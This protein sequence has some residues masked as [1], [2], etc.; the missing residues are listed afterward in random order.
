MPAPARV[1]PGTHLVNSALRPEGDHRPA[2]RRAVQPRGAACPTASRA[3]PVARPPRGFPP[4]PALPIPPTVPRSRNS[5]RHQLSTT[6]A[7]FSSRLA[8]AS[9]AVRI[10]RAGTPSEQ[11]PHA[12]LDLFGAAGLSGAASGSRLSKSKLATCR[13]ELIPSNRATPF[14]PGLPVEP[15]RPDWRGRAD[16]TDRPDQRSVQTRPTPSRRM[17][18]HPERT[19]RPKPV[20]RASPRDVAEGP[21]GCPRCRRPRRLGWPALGGGQRP[22]AGDTARVASRPERWPRRMASRP[23]GR[24]REPA[25]HPTRTWPSRSNGQLAGSHLTGGH[26]TSGHGPTA[27][28]RT[29]AAHS[30]GRTRHPGRSTPDDAQPAGEARPTNHHTRIP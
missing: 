24:P 1:V 22:A 6:T 3:Q 4:T 28:A 2:K 18:T 25:S 19:R 10:S 16:T 8:P 26:R 17:A 27:T 23:D 29:A 9:V 30:A 13:T 7:S 20:D 21:T 12:A 14:E 15:G 11:Y 5:E